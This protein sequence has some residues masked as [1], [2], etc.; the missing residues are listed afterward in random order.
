M[1]RN[2]LLGLSQSSTARTL[3]TDTPL[4]V[5]SRRFVPG[6]AVEDLIGTLEQAHAEG[7][8]G[9]GNYLGEA[10]EEPAHARTAAETYA[11]VLERMAEA[12]LEP[13]VSLKFTQ[14][15]QRISERCLDENLE[16]VLSTAESAS[17][18]IRFDMESSAYTTRTLDAFERLWAEGHR[19]VTSRA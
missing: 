8:T 12:G 13:N 6:E 17:A 1:L 18:F 14:L 3:V 11:R 5:L 7:M 4:R 19:K 15:G 10:V 2:V 9:T 16:R